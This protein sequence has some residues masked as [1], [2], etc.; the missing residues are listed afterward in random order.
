MIN[1][2]IDENVKTQLEEV[3]EEMG[4]TVTTAFTMSTKSDQ[5]EKNSL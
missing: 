2:R 5:R 3:C 4:I 1:F